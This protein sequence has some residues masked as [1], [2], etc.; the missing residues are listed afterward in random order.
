MGF[1]P[2][3]K[4]VK[5]M[6]S[7]TL[8]GFVAL[9][10]VL[11]LAFVILNK[12]SVTR[13]ESAVKTKTPTVS[14]TTV[15]VKDVGTMKKEVSVTETESGFEPQTVTVKVG[16]KVVWTNKSGATGNVS[17]AKHPTHL[18]YPP[19]NLTN[20]E[21]GETL[22]LVFDTAGTYKYHDHLNPSRFGTVVVE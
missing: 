8:L 2:K 13:E 14:K 1:V 20:Y 6:N 3:R 10:F 11:V 5:K 9:I 17:S 22:S 12:N 7:K 15:E 16:T 18:E 21:V 19:L 4:E